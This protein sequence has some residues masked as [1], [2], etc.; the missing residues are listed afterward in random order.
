MINPFLATG[1]GFNNT[2]FHVVPAGDVSGDLYVGGSFTTYNDMQANQL[3][4]L[5][6]N[7][8]L[9]LPFATATGFGNT[10]LRVL[11][12]GDASGDV[13]RRPVRAVPVHAHWQICAPHIHWSLRP[14]R[15]F[16]Q[17]CSGGSEP[18]LKTS[19]PKAQ[20]SKKMTAAIGVFEDCASMVRVW[21]ASGMPVFGR[22]SQKR[23][24]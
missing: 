5:N 24:I 17:T 4:R 14:L 18:Q 11:P 21:L 15:D 10:V 7:G 20:D 1:K 2:V 23:T 3:V 6:Q 12:V 8:T 22:V 16:S 9:D 13:C 19:N